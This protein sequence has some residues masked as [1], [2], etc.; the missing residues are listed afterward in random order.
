MGSPTQPEGAGWLDMER[1]ESALGRKLT[2]I[3]LVGG[4]FCS[5]CQSTFGNKK[6]YDSHY[7]DHN[8]GDADIGYTCVVCRKQ[9]SG[10]PSF[11][12]HCY[13][14]HVAKNKHRCLHCSKT[15]SKQSILNSHI[16]AT[17]N[18][19]CETCQIH[20]PSKK[21]LTTHQ[22]VHGK[23]KPP[24]NCQECG[25]HIESIDMCE[26]HIDKHCTTVYSCPVCNEQT[27][28]KLDAA[29]HLTIH[30]GEVLTDEDITT[31]KIGE[32]CSIDILGGVLCNYCDELFKNRI[33]FD[34]HYT[35]EHG[36]K[37]LVYS[38]NICGK[39]YDKYH[40][41]G[42]HC[43]DHMTKGRFE[44][45]DCGKSFCRLSL[46]VT[47]TEAFHSADSGDKPFRCGTCGYGFKSAK[48]LCEHTRVVHATSALRCT[49]N[50][51]NEMFES[52][53]ELLF[54]QRSHRSAL[55]NWCRQCGLQFSSLAAA[56]RHLDVHRKK[57]YACPVCPKTYREKYLILK[58][59]PTHFESVLHVCKVCGKVFNQRSRLVQHS[60]THSALRTHTCSV[61]SKG[62]MKAAVLEQHMNIHLGYRPFKCTVC[63][64]TFA[65][66]PNF[67]KHMRRIHNIPKKDIQTFNNIMKTT[68]EQVPVTVIDNSDTK[69]KIE[70]GIDS[71]SSEMS[72]ETHSFAESDDST[73]DSID[74]TIIKRDWSISNES[75]IIENIDTLQYTDMLPANSTTFIDFEL[76]TEVMS[77]QAT[78]AG[79]AW[80]G[81]DGQLLLPGQDI[82]GL[83]GQEPAGL[84]PAEYGP[85]FNVASG[86][87]SGGVIDLDEQ[88]LPHIDPRLTIKPP[89][90]APPADAWEPIITK[91]YS[92]FEDAELNRLSILKTD[93]F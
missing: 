30:F 80:P 24:Y 67:H 35:T 2:S 1:L 78:P 57:H 53:K 56:E 66:H 92:V 69:M 36:D 48:R 84:V 85:E 76:S 44:C 42:N 82:Q 4:I 60:K 29:K 27:N 17:H 23:E 8:I 37:P 86:V 75:S 89:V 72:L 7:V 47:H 90:E 93:I 10:Y 63:P 31:S 55:D 22:V 50:G 14:A 5:I 25:D 32:D 43:Y 79:Q 83:A 3:D 45:T 58:H 34:T 16:D 20:F 59:V 64:K 12:N 52:L 15:F 87:W 74:P 33:E 81:Q 73:M 18:F 19:R 65:S 61:C 28:N 62:F 49:Q 88:Y 40:L 38:C 54:H 46:L 21:E 51:C 11:R 39:Q 13:L 41:F 77:N 68:P 9:F 6:D 70:S 71:T 26:L 91:V